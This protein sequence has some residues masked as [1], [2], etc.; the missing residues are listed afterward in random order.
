MDEILNLIQS[1]S[2]SFPSYFFLKNLFIYDIL[3]LYNHIFGPGAYMIYGTI[4]ENY[5]TEI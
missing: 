3:T 1:V 5:T 4:T 2:E